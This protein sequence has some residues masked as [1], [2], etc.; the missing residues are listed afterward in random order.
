MISNRRTG[1]RRGPSNHF[2]PSHDIFGR[3]NARG[4]DHDALRRI[5]RDVDGIRA[6]NE[7]M[8]RDGPTSHP[9]RAAMRT[10]AAPPTSRDRF[11]PFMEAQQ[12]AWPHHAMEAARRR[13]PCGAKL[14][15][16]DGSTPRQRQLAEM[17]SLAERCAQK[18][19]TF[20]S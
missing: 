8:M 11:A 16:G 20:S 5:S 1:I 9:R 3:G 17:Y 2:A 4:G 15:H 10:S 12:R 7:R 13:D 14:S 18:V 19:C 6:A